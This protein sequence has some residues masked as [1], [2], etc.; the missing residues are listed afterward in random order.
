MIIQS[1]DIWVKLKALNEKLISEEKHCFKIFCRLRN[2]ANQMMEKRQIQDYDIEVKTSLIMH[3]SFN[4]PNIKLDEDNYFQLES[5]DFMIFQEEKNEYSIL[6]FHKLYYQYDIEKR[7]VLNLCY[8]LHN[9]Y[10]HHGFTA[11]DLFKIETFFMEV[12]IN[13]QRFICLNVL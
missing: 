1:Q 6:D 10:D 12:N 9:L 2:Q 5:G 11:D 7:E 3:K 4:N 13:H 8:T